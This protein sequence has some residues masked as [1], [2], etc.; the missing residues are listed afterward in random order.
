M[1]IFEKKFDFR[2]YIKT[3]CGL[4]TFNRLRTKRGVVNRLRFIQFTV[5]AL[6]VDTFKRNQRFDD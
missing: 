4:D 5:C 2:V 3:K 1:K 6:I